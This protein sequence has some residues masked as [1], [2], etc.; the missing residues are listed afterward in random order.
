MGEDH[1]ETA[2]I[3]SA[4]GDVCVQAWQSCKG[5]QEGKRGYTCGLWQVLHSLAARVGPEEVGG[6][7]W[8][9]GVRWEPAFTAVCEVMSYQVR[10]RHF[11]SLIG[12]SSSNLGAL[13]KGTIAH[14]AG[15]MQRIGLQ[16]L[17]VRC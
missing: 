13:L 11:I 2:S 12:S 1:R 16:V 4:F 15:L 10:S 6:A 14:S 5:S 8:M 17:G 3:L 9:H 7:V